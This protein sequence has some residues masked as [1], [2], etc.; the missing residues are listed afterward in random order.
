M[1]N[2]PQNAEC[3]AKQRKCWGQEG[4]YYCVP[5]RT[6]CPIADLGL[7]VDVGAVPEGASVK[8]VSEGL[9]LWYTRYQD[10]D[11]EEDGEVDSPSDSPNS[12]TDSAIS[13]VGFKP[14]YLN[15]FKLACRTWFITNF[16][17][18]KDIV[19]DILQNQ[20]YLVAVSAGFFIVISIGCL[21]LSMLN[22][23]D[24]RWKFL[25]STLKLHYP[26]PT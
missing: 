9:W 21:A 14:N 11:G 19:I 24:Y 4:V 10:E 18:H 13:A 2:G 5:K 22:M 23:C 7:V 20:L 16:L 12:P 25:Q 26:S 1:S 15:P 3:K 6:Q 8:P 17:V